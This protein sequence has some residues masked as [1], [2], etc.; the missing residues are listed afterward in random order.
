MWDRLLAFLPESDGRDFT[1]VFESRVW[2]KFSENGEGWFPGYRGWGGGSG[3]VIAPIS[4][5]PVLFRVKT[6]PF[7]S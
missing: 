4:S 6:L 1:Y 7:L 2:E 5:V 3:S